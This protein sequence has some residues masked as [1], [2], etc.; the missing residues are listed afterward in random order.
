MHSGG[1]GCDLPYCQKANA[2]YS[3]PFLSVSH[4]YFGQ[5]LVKDEEHGEGKVVAFLVLLP[6]IFA[7]QH[8]SLQ[9][10]Y[11]DRQPRFLFQEKRLNSQ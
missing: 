10:C 8:V 5:Q 2:V 3:I 1:S 9:S 4:V 11:S 7:E 6:P